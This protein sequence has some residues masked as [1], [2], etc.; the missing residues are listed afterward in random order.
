LTST[1]MSDD[2]DTNNMHSN[3][4]HAVDEYALHKPLCAPVSVCMRARAFVCRRLWRDDLLFNVYRISCLG[5]IYVPGTY[6]I[7]YHHPDISRHNIQNLRRRK[8]VLQV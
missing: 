5:A 1:T 7:L 8:K 4:A 3:N 2:L 6:C